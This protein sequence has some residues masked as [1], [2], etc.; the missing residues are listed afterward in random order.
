MK[1]ENHNTMIKTVLQIH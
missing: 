1:K